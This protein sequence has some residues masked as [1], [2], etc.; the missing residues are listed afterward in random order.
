[1]KTAAT[2]QN[3]RV[4]ITATRGAVTRSFDRHRL[5]KVA[6][7][8]LVARAGFYVVLAILT[9]EVAVNRGGKQTDGHGALSFIASTGFG[10][11]LIGLSALGFLLLG[12]TRIVAAVRDHD[13]SAG[14]RWAAGL[15]GALYCAITAVP[16]SF[17]AGDHS[18]ASQ[19]SQHRETHSALTM[20]GG[21][22]IVAVAGVIVIG[23]CLWQI[24]RAI[25][26]DFTEK[27]RLPASASV[28]TAV[29][30]TGRAGI[31]AR[32]MVFLPVGGFLIA[33]AVTAN[34]H[35]AGGLDTELQTLANQPWGPAVLA[36]VVAGLLTFAA[37]AALEARY[38]DVTN[39]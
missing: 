36:V 10:D 25:N 30:W 34:P 14:K 3:H 13:E 18:V 15:Q 29:I 17:L 2:G 20:P 7:L 16:I 8:G 28:R 5:G 4:S 24:K 37:Y 27:L 23:A 35:K 12:I 21:R 39:A 26:S 33:A 38:R 19:Q 11:V 9:A 22:F 31:A 6:R 1:L 32:A